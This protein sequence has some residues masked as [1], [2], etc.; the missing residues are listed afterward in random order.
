MA[1]RSCYVVFAFGIFVSVAHAQT[2]PRVPGFERFYTAP[3]PKSAGADEEPIK[4]N[5][6]TGGRILLGELNCLSCHSADAEVA[7]ST[8]K[9][10]I[11]DDV[12]N[13]VKVD[14]LRAYLSSPHTVKP[15]ST[16]PDLIAALPEATRAS[17]VEALTHFLAS[18]G[19]LTEARHDP[20]AAKKGADYFRKIGCLACHNGIDESAP[21]LAT[22]ISLLHVGKKYS[23]P[24]LMEFLKDPIKIRPSGRMPDL[25]LSEDELRS[26]AN[27]FV[28]DG[29]TTPNVKYS[30][31]HG[32]WNSLPN[33]SELKPVAKGQTSG[34]D[35]SVADRTHQFAVRFSSSL[36]IVKP[37][38][39]RFWLGSDDGSKLIVDDEV[40]VDCDGVHPYE[41]R[42]GQKALAVGFHSVVVE[43]FQGGGESSL[44]VQIASQGLTRQ[45]LSGLLFLEPKLPVSTPD[46]PVFTPDSNLIATGRELFATI[47]CAS[48]HEMKIDSQL[49]SSKLMA[50]PLSTVNVKNG[51]LADTVTGNAPRYG[52]SSLQRTSIVTALKTRTTD[53]PAETIHRTLTTLNCYACHE[54][55][56]LGGVEEARNASFE[57]LQKEMG[58]EGRL[59]PTLTGVGDKLRPEWLRQLLTNGTNER[60]NYL[61]TRMPKF[62]PGNV[63]PMVDQFAAVDRKPD[64]LPKADFPEPEYRVKAAGRHLV[65]GQALSCIKCHDFGTHPSTGVRAINLVT[66]HQRLRP[67][68]FYRY[69]LD[70]QIYRRGTRMPAPWPFGQTTIRDTLN[71][72]VNLQIQAVWL[73]LSDRDKAAIPSGLVRESIELKPQTEP[74]IYRNFIEGAGSRAIGVGYPE[75]VNLAFDANDMRLA[76]IWHGAFIDASRHWTGRGAGFEPPLGDDVIPLPGKVPFVT[77]DQPDREFPTET[78][79]EIG[80]KFLGYT[81]DPQ[82]RPIFRYS[83]QNLSIED[84]F[85][86]VKETDK[87]G[88]LRR[89]LR[90]AGSA[91]T[92]QLWFRAATAGRLDELG[93]GRYRIDNVWTIVIRS[94][95]SV[96]PL[97]RESAGRKELLVPIRLKNRNAEVALDY[98]W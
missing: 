80:Y 59:P 65:G 74:I 13:R 87:R 40:V 86:P 96:K 73:Y 19:N 89:T 14:W 46:N 3:L 29:V 33:F 28:R 35:L 37:G 61:V 48:C 23:T 85:V 24:S 44:A 54:R 10:P 77:L 9:A 75:G 42:N 71:A 57:S 26:I 11:L 8:K 27:Y 93:Q 88:T 30:V 36:R 21:D 39:Y 60:K 83:M 34:F 25:G 4:L 98:V 7:I 64:T 90:F 95:D 15:G 62:G 53:N 82:Q 31:F 41:R 32:Q 17:T 69:V 63:E 16:M 81:L 2:H 12:G 51:C 38:D 79:R 70:P 52:L 56:K 84:H 47:G 66:M 67:E 72:D 78:G 55:D 45:P 58:D 68:W 20:A 1:L 5:P 22:S 92:S 76:M 94:S 97:I 91:D 43:Y 50:K 49:I 6:V 18:T